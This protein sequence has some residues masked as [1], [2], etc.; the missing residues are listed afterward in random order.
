MLNIFLV[1]QLA[2]LSME[3]QIACSNLHSLSIVLFDD[4]Y[5]YIALRVTAWTIS[6]QITRA[7]TYNPHRW[8]MYRWIRNKSRRIYGNVN[9][10]DNAGCKGPQKGFRNKAPKKN[11][12]LNAWVGE[13]RDTDV[14]IYAQCTDPSSGPFESIR[15][16]RL[17]DREE[18]EICDDCADEISVSLNGGPGPFRVYSRVKGVRAS[19][20]A[21]AGVAETNTYLPILPNRST[22]YSNVTYMF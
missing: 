21:Q 22:S 18:I 15:T 10:R 5:H 4:I 9:Q 16:S 19:L 17:D 3:I 14:Y 2:Q 11:V 8:I 12:E 20:G 1:S 13:W 7:R 6:T